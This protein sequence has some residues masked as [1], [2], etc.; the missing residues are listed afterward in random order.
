MHALEYSLEKN[1]ILIQHLYRREQCGLRRFSRFSEMTD[2][3]NVETVDRLRQVYGNVDDIDLF[4]GG[5]AERPVTGGVVGPTF[6]C[7]IGQQFLNLRKGDRF[8]YENGNH[9]GAF[10]S[11]Q[12]QELRKASLSRVICDGLDDIESL[13]PFA[14]L[15]VDGFNNQRK[16]CKGTGIPRVNLK[17]WAEKPAGPQ[18]L[19]SLASVLPDLTNDLPSNPQFDDED[20][21]FVQYL[22][23]K[24]YL[25]ELA[26]APKPETDTN[27][28]PK[29][30]S[31]DNY[32]H[33]YDNEPD[34]L[35]GL[36]SGPQGRSSEE[37]SDLHKRF[38]ELLSSE[39]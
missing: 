36:T 6:A 10:N 31:R 27:E 4:T 9:P 3:I 39:T 22:K 18:Q 24:T 20:A 13:Q 26:L 14:F 7:I 35:F 25:E 32:L 1:N 8:W 21:D 33:V 29:P 11:A 12:L 16:A 23:D 19:S 17:L 38:E 37:Q 2:V 15:T 34:P 5:L 28:V 30:L